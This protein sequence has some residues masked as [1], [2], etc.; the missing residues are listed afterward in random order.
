MLILNSFLYLLIILH[1]MTHISPLWALFAN[2]CPPQMS[3]YYSLWT[4]VT[5]NLLL[6][7]ESVIEGWRLWLVCFQKNI[8][9]SKGKS[10]WAQSSENNKKMAKCSHSFPIHQSPPLI[11][12]SPLTLCCS[13]TERRRGSSS[14]IA[15]DWRMEKWKDGV[16]AQPA[17]SVSTHT[18]MALTSA[19]FQN[20]RPRVL[21]PV[22]EEKRAG[23]KLK[24]IL[25]P[26]PSWLLPEPLCYTLHVTT[27]KLTNWPNRP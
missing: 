13:S 26:M 22:S 21:H 6:C 1:Q 3:C 18:N 12:V 7:L 27:S 19:P 23:A 9:I 25:Q 20:W 11:T 24:G 2:N 10:S 15:G 4:H 5:G 14:S 16:S 17:S 8:E